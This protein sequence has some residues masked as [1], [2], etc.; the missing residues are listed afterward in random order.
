MPDVPVSVI[1]GTVTTW[2]ER[3][4]RPALVAANRETAAAFPQGRHARA[5]RSS[6][7]VPFTQPELVAAEV[8]RVVELAREVTAGADLTAGRAARPASSS[9]PRPGRPGRRGPSAGRVAAVA[10]T[11]V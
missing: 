4:R 1:S 11:V 3:A 7:Y 9:P 2:I 10:A 5:E 8:L 6:H